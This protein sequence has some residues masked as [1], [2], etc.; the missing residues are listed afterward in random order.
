MIQHVRH[1]AEASFAYELMGKTHR[2]GP[3]RR[4]EHAGSLPALF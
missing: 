4:R 3:A 1:E 2:K